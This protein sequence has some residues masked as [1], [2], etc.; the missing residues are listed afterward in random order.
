M[1]R[2]RY[3]R[4]R[5][6]GN[7][8]TP[9]SAKPQEKNARPNSV[10]RNTQRQ[11]LRMHV[12]TRPTTAGTLVGHR[13][14]P[15]KPP[16]P[17]PLFGRSLR[18][19]VDVRIPWPLV[20]GNSLNDMVF[21]T[22]NGIKQTIRENQQKRQPVRYEPSGVGWVDARTWSAMAAS[23]TPENRRRDAQLNPWL[24]LH[25]PEKFACGG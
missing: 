18:F 25:M 12:C 15:W 13:V 2:I 6:N 22:G 5:R 1:W 3:R 10:A 11:K 21:Y 24:R 8:F 4:R 23:S 14:S 16:C 20:Q 7:T 9:H 19:S 17:V